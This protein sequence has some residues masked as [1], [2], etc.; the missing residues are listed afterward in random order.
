MVDSMVDEH[1]QKLIIQAEFA[2][3]AGVSRE[4]VRKASTRGLKAAMVD[5]FVDIAH[6]D[7]QAYIKRQ[8]D[9]KTKKTPVATKPKP[10]AKCRAATKSKPKVKTPDPAAPPESVAPGE[11]IPLRFTEAAALASVLDLTLRELVSRYGT[12]RQFKGYVDAS[13][14]LADI[15]NKDLKSA[16][17]EGTL[18]PR[19]TVK[20]HLF[21]AIEN[22][23]LRLLTDIPKTIT[24]RLS[25]LFKSGSTIED[26]EVVVRDL[27]GAHVKGVKA[28]AKRVLKNV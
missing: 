13:K 16:E 18:I 28:T 9:K 21:G 15:R 24:R 11:D 14:V 26:C 1:P 3:E 2:N 25:A 8:Q 10:R 27:L 6:L 12:A 22:N 17:L 7:A 19:A 5:G 4:A 23:N 20:T